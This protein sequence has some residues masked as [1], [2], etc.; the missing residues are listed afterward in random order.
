MAEKVKTFVENLQKWLGDKWRLLNEL[1]F[2]LSFTSCFLYLLYNLLFVDEDDR[3]S[4]EYASLGAFISAFLAFVAFLAVTQQRA[5]PEKQTGDKFKKNKKY[6]SD[7]ELL[8]T[9]LKES[10][11]KAMVSEQQKRALI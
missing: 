9:H 2:V 3:I 7:K 6:S 5:E 8:N 1:V 4:N 10:L 11:R